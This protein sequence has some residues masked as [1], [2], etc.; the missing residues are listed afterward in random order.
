[1]APAAPAGASS[2]RHCEDHRPVDD[3]DCD[4]VKDVDDNCPDV[5]NEDQRNTDAGP[6][7][8]TPREPPAADGSTAAMAD[9][10]SAGDACDDDDDAD[11]RPDGA[12]NCPVKRN[13]LQQ[14]SNADGVGDAC[15]EQAV[16]S[17]GDGTI[18][19]DDNC[20]TIS[21]PGQEDADGDRVGDACDNDVDG[22]GV[23]NSNDNC[24]T[25][26]NPG[27]KDEN[28]DGIG[29]ACQGSSDTPAPAPSA[30]SPSDRVVPRVAL[31]LPRRILRGE[32]VGGMPLRVACSEA[33]RLSATVTVSSAMRRKLRLRSAIIARAEGALGA[34]GETYLI[35][36]PARGAAGRLRG[37]RVPIRVVVRAQDG[38]G[39][40]TSVVRATRLG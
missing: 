11:T 1:M 4:F 7:V 14:D 8:Y 25:V 17:D 27:Q 9:G 34:S 10:D 18:D 37:R 28:A 2:A 12:D 23:P 13:P 22:D 21:N 36:A 15:P 20:S 35:F 32:L 40:R 16:D 26:S 19:R 39:N 5:S 31:S 38:A 29:Y 33:C 24:P 30:P 6:P 3:Y